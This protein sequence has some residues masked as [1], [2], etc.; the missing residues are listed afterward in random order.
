M[1][2]QAKAIGALL[3]LALAAG[4]VQGCAAYKLADGPVEIGY[5]ALDD[6]RSAQQTAISVVNDPNVPAGVKQ[7]IRQADYAANPLDNPQ[8]SSIH[9]LRDK[10]KEYVAIKAEIEALEA[11]GRDPTQERIEEAMLALAA[12]RSAITT[13][14][15]L[16]QHLIRAARHF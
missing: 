13:A 14:Q 4:S 8:A 6:Y 12:V 15:P 5:V 3:A 16:I 7:A 2:T 1:R 10:L 11:A 9:I